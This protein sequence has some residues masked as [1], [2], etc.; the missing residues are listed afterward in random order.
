VKRQSKIES[1]IT[2]DEN[3]TYA[4]SLHSRA[5]DDSASPYKHVGLAPY[6]LDDRSRLKRRKAKIYP[7]KQKTANLTNRRLDSGFA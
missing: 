2:F 1:S 5:D 6:K 4:R 7:G 3:G